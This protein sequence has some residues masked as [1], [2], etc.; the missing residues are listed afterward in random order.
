MA[1][2]PFTHQVYLEHAKQNCGR[3]GHESNTHC[4]QHNRSHSD[5][6]PSRGR[7]PPCN[8]RLTRPPLLRR[9]VILTSLGEDGVSSPWLSKNHM[10]TFR[11]GPIIV[12]LKTSPFGRYSIRKS[13]SLETDITARTF[14][15][16]IKGKERQ[17]RRSLPSMPNALGPS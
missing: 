5:V 3:F 2:C 12:G 10:R 16:F 1:R 17:S 9:H 7:G 15:H 4:E 6:C 8:R 11:L 13:M 14:R